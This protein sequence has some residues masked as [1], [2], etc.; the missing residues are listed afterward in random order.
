MV[1]LEEARERKED[2]GD[3]STYP[4][5]EIEVLVCDGLDVKSYRRY[6]GNDLSNLNATSVSI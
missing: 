1:S 6:G 3:A 4:D 5:V 2:G